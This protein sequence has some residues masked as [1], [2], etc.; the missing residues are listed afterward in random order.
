MSQRKYEAELQEE[1]EQI[2]EYLYDICEDCRLATDSDPEGR[3]FVICEKHAQEES[4][5]PF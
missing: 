3:S 1:Q 4:E 5:L 2:E